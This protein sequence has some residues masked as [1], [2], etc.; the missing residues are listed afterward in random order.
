[1]AVTQRGNVVKMTAIGDVYN[2]GSGLHAL[3]HVRSAVF[4]SAGTAGLATVLDGIA[5]G[6]QEVLPAYLAANAS[7]NLLEVHADIPEGLYVSA[8]PDNAYVLIYL[9]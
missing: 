6:G 3:V 2:P 9:A 5:A 7:V 1:M 4:V 8:L